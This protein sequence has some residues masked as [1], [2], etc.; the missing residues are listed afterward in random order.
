MQMRMPKSWIYAPF[1]M[2]IHLFLI[3]K[4]IAIEI[5]KIKNKKFTKKVGYYV[6]FFTTHKYW[7]PGNPG[8]YTAVLK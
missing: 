2:I 7:T 3:F 1:G 5:V 6:S 8:G 4:W